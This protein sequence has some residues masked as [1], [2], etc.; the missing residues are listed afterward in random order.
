[1]TFPVDD[2]NLD[3]LEAAC[4][5]DEGR[6]HLAEFLTFGQVRLP[7]Y[8]HPETMDGVEMWVGGWSHVDVIRALLAEV[9]RLREATDA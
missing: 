5:P 2:M 3:L 7:A 9:R 8:E 4:T 6:T 1:V